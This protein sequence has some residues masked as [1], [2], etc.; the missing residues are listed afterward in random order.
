MSND[1]GDMGEITAT[2]EDS[3][4][5]AFHQL[6]RELL[7]EA[8]FMIALIDGET[9]QI[10]I[11]Y[12]YERGQKVTI[13]PFPPGEDPLSSL[14]KTGQPMV[15]SESTRGRDMD[16][17]ASGHGSGA[18]SWLGVPLIVEGHVFGALIVQDLD[19]ED[20]FGE[21]DQR[22]LSALSRQAGIAIHNAR[23]LDETAKFTA[24]QHIVS[25]LTNKL[26]ASTNVETILR[27]ALAEL[28]KLMNASRG[29]ILLDIGEGDQSLDERR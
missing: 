19:V 6:V 15:L 4:Y 18:I 5:P 13:R 25:E 1:W 7:G 8:D 14:I 12:A 20:R 17:G 27:F 10:E 24:H 9:N 29:Y 11:P 22:K 16:T 21:S 28:G 26:W 3:L 2:N 23:L